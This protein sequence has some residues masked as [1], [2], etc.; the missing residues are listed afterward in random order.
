MESLRHPNIVMF[1][2]ASTKFPNLSIIL[3]YCANRSLWSVLQNKAIALSWEDRRRIAIEIALGMNYLHSFSTPIIHRDLKSL[4]IL[5]DDCFRAKIAD[6]GWT[7]LKGDK[8]TNKIGT[9]QWMAPEV[10]NG[11]IYTEKADIFSYA[12][13]LWEIAAREP[14]YKNIMGTKV[15]IDVIKYDLR[16]EIPKTTPEPFAK[17]TK[18]C[19]VL[20]LGA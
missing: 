15:S 12:I 20:S 3:E 9:F 16:P 10:I 7:R 19:W 5:L 18:R 14:P 17:L 1:L 4:N 2:G 11:E 13:I 8:M 6:F